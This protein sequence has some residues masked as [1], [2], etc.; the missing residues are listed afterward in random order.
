MNAD[1]ENVKRTQCAS[2]TSKLNKKCDKL[3]L[4]WSLNQCL[5][6]NSWNFGGNEV[7]GGV[8][9]AK[10]SGLW[11]AP[12]T[13]HTIQ[14]RNSL[15]PKELLVVKSRLSRVLAADSTF[16]IGDRLDRPTR[17]ISGSIA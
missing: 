2:H 7:Y 13:P 14:F 3:Q 16:M 1:I 6:Y 9:S 11:R 8:T 5:F 17:S 10:G 4:T 12:L 15:Q